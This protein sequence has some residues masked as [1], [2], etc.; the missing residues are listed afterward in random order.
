[1]KNITVKGMKLWQQIIEYIVSRK[2]DAEGLFNTML[3][4]FKLK[5]AP[6]LEPEHKAGPEPKL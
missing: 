5:A 3:L 1:M 4:S 6:F 2:P